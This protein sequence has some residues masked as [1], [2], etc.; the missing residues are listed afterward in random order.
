MSTIKTSHILS[1]IA[2][3]EF[4]M[5]TFSKLIYLPHIAT[6]F[7]LLGVRTL[8][9]YGVLLVTICVRKICFCKNNS[10]YNTEPH[11]FCQAT[12][13]FMYNSLCGKND[14]KFAKS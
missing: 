5:L 13:L 6:G 14:N 9:I 8:A 11:I 12:V 4:S 1:E 2:C 3:M 10:E 7:N